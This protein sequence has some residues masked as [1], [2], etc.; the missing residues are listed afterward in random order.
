MSQ[1]RG[2]GSLLFPLQGE[3]KRR[4]HEHYEPFWYLFLV[5]ALPSHFS[6]KHKTGKEGAT[7]D[8]TSHGKLTAVPHSKPNFGPAAT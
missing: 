8:L 1:C 5:A 7:C 2:V 6:G 3:Q 4:L